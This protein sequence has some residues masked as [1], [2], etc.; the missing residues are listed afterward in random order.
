M[1]ERSVAKTGKERTPVATDD[2]PSSERPRKDRPGR[3]TTT[4]HVPNTL[5]IRGV[6]NIICTFW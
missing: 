6:L 1:T 5:F 2:F 3:Q 4:A